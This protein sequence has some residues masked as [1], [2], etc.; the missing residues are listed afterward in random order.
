MTTSVRTAQVGTVYLLHFHQPYKH[1]R[2]YI[3]WTTDL[4]ARLSAHRHGRGARLLAVISQAGIDWTLA[5]TW[6]G[7]RA[8]E[9][10]I[11]IQGGAS[12]VCPCCGVVPHLEHHVW[13]RIER[14]RIARRLLRLV[15]LAWLADKSTLD[16]I[17]RRLRRQ[18]TH[19][20]GP[21]TPGQLLSWTERT[22]T[23][24]LLTY[25]KPY[26]RRD[27]S[28]WC[29]QEDTETGCENACRMVIDTETGLSLLLPDYL[30]N[31]NATVPASMQTGQPWPLF[32]WAT[33]EDLTAGGLR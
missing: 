13:Q 21:L 24:N 16:R 10:Q 30:I 32:R 31:V 15:D 3:G 18:L 2:H 14:A 22:P 33:R 6:H 20:T 19:S 28:V 1:A 25:T 4:D 17:D 11:K 9:R 5:R 29:V 8:R 23:M 12:R 27:G 26:V 7:P